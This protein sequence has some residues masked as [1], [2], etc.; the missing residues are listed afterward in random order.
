[1]ANE[2]IL[3]RLEGLR[4]MLLALYQSSDKVLGK[5]SSI[6]GDEREIFVSHFLR[7]ILPPNYRIGDGVITDAQGNISTQLDVV[8]ELPFAPSFSFLDGMSRTYLADTI[9]AVIEIKS[10]LNGYLAQD[11]AKPGNVYEKFVNGKIDT[12]GE[13]MYTALQR[14]KRNV[15]VTKGISLNN[16]FAIEIRPSYTIPAYVIG[17]KGFAS[18]DPLLYHISKL[19]RTG[20]QDELDIV[21]GILQ[22]GFKPEN[23]KPIESKTLFVGSKGQIWEGGAALGAFVNSL[24]WELHRTSPL[25]WPNL[26]A[27]YEAENDNKSK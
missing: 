7:Q 23:S 18:A 1:M 4:D 22:L 12:N 25:S 26:P 13:V 6:T 11:S 21:R 20:Q 8:I 24:H 27:Y 10:D 16:G 9:G 3:Q 17:Y 2:L 5:H 15:L 19:N 14:V